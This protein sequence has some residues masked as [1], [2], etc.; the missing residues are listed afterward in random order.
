MARWKTLSKSE[1]LASCIENSHMVFAS[2]TRLFIWE[3]MSQVLENSKQYAKFSK[4]MILAKK[5]LNDTYF[6]FPSEYYKQTSD[7]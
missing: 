3:E 1:S 6:S 5:C 2:K 7:T 4:M